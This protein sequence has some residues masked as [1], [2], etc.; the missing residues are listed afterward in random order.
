MG[1]NIDLKHKF[2]DFW[3][4]REGFSIKLERFYDEHEGGMTN[5]RIMQWMEAVY[6]QGARD[7]AQD[8]L[9]T[10]GDYAC[11]VSGC[12]V[13]LRNPSQ[14]YDAAHGSLMVYY[15]KVLDEDV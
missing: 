2:M 6:R 3:N 10:L 14:G 7:M 5:E 4:Q 13:P 1:K 11:A 15:T 8:T 9:D 12:E